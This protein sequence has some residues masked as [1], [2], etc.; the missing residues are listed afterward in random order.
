M[1]GDAHQGCPHLRCRAEQ[2]V[3]VGLLPV[4]CGAH[5]HCECL[6]YQIPRH[7]GEPDLR[8]AGRDLRG[9][10]LRTGVTVIPAEPRNRVAVLRRQTE[11]GVEDRRRERKFGVPGC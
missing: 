5:R 8:Q 6:E 10:V 1:L 3:T 2:V 4:H 11:G 9:G 7:G